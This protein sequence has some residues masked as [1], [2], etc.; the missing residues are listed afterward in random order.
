[1]KV[2]RDG[3]PVTVE[4]TTDG[5]GLVSHA[6]SALLGQVADKVGLTSGL[7]LRLGVLKQ[8]RRGHD[9]GRVIR[10]VAV[11]LADG[12]ECVAD[13]GGQ[14]DQ[15]ALFGPVASDFTAFRVI[16]RVASTPGLLDAVR[17]AH[18][19]ARARFWELHGAPERLT[20]DVDATLIT[21]HAEKERAAGNYK[22]RLW[23][24]PDAVLSG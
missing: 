13:L 14:R 6:G 4:V 1:L 22:G 17:I 3:R 15:D 16:D 8:R 12:G 5:S 10:D 2:M 11:M 21:A 23:V 18:A 24:S 20:I 19:R 7:S 9:P